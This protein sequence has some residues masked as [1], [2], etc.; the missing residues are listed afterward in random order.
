MF[1]IIADDELDGNWELETLS[2][3]AGESRLTCTL[4]MLLSSA[5]LLPVRLVLKLGI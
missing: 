4:K 2:E 1:E 3:K 5:G